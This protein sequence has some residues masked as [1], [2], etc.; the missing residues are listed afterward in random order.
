M[1]MICPEATDCRVPDCGHRGPHP[2][3]AGCTYH[4]NSHIILGACPECVPFKTPSGQHC[5]GCG[6]PVVVSDE[7]LCITCKGV[8]S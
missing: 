4:E 5:K 1:T 6:E 7:T 3:K 2:H 8:V